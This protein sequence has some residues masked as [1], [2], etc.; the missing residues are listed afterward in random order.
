MEKKGWKVVAII[1]VI[2]FIV[3]TLGICYMYNIGVKAINKESECA[4]NICYNN[5]YNSYTLEGDVCGCWLD[6]ELKYKEIMK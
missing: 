3:E 2:L 4:T 5:G 6:G 1:F